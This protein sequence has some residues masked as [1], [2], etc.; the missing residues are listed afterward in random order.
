MS[1]QKA[2]NTVCIGVLF[3]NMQGTARKQCKIVASTETA[4]GV[5]KSEN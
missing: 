3:S 1:K 2:E 4:L 5:G